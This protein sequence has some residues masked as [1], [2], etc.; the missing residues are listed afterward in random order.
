LRFVEKL[1]HRAGRGV[2]GT[3]GAGIL[4]QISHAFFVQA[5]TKDNTALLQTGTL[6]VGLFFLLRAPCRAAS[7]NTCSRSLPSSFLLTLGCALP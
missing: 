6:G 3:V 7:R 2:T 1:E 4:M 5:A